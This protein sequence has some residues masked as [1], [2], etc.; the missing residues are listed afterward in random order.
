MNRKEYSLLGGPLYA[1]P[2]MSGGTAEPCRDEAPV[3]TIFPSLSLLLV[4]ESFWIAWVG[5]QLTKR[6]GYECQFGW[7][8]THRRSSQW[9]EAP[10]QLTKEISNGSNFQKAAL[11]IVLG[12]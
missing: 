10:T 8:N 4:Q 1:R 7:E 6:S 3:D 9:D 11:P 5:G 12:D 2:R